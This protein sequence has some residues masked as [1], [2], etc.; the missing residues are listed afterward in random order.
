MVWPGWDNLPALV[1]KHRNKPNPIPNIILNHIKDVSKPTLKYVYE[2]DVL[3]E[4]YSNHDL[5]DIFGKE[6]MVD[7]F[8]MKLENIT[9]IPFCILMIMESFQEE[10]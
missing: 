4:P 9:L 8:T 10:V 3:N 5:M 1:S 7:W 2:W 6:I